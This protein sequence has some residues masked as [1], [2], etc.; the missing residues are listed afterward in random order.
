M[1]KRLTIEFDDTRIVMGRAS[2]ADARVRRQVYEALAETTTEANIFAFYITQVESATNYPFGEKLTVFPGEVK[3]RAI[4]SDWAE[5]TDEI[6]MDE[7]QKGIIVLRSNPN[8]DGQK[9]TIRAI[10]RQYVEME[11]IPTL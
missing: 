10:V 5:K 9:K 8:M 1:Q 3:T 4:F 11:L 6:L 7:I 2:A